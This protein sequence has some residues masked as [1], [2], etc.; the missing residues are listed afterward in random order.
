MSLVGCVAIIVT[1][2]IL[3]VREEGWGG[4]V[5]IAEVLRRFRR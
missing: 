1:V 3:N 4:V 2:T 5:T